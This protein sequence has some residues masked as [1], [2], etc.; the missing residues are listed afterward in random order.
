ML[1]EKFI[2]LLETLKRS[3]Y[4][5]G[6]ARVVSTSPHVAMQLP[7]AKYSAPMASGR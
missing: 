7:I 4:A 3:G 5:D 2:L 6:G 1:D